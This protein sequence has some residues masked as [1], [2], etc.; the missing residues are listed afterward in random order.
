[1]K[2]DAKLG[3]DSINQCANVDIDEFWNGKRIENGE[4]ARRFENLIY[5]FAY[6]C[7][8]FSTGETG[9]YG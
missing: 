9:M 8:P 3:G 1:L 4:D 2:A 5:Q 6:E 7:L